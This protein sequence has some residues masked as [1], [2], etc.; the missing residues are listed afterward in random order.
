MILI[1]GIIE[2]IIMKIKPDKIEDKTL[3]EVKTGQKRRESFKMTE[4]MTFAT[5]IF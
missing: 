1:I 2:G 4:K 5:K 3:K